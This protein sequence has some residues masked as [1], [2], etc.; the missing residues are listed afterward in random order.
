MTYLLKIKR[1]L[2]IRNQIF[3]LSINFCLDLGQI[4]NADR[5]KPIV[6]AFSHKT[7]QMILGLFLV[8]LIVFR[9]L[10]YERFHFHICD[11]D[12]PSW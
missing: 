3:V 5:N 1:H 10:A 2:E 11:C 4:L 12:A 9:T 8:A 6:R 7:D